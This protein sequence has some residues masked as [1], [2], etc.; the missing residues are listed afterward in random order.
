MVIDHTHLLHQDKHVYH[1]EENY[2]ISR[3]TTFWLW[4]LEQDFYYRNNDAPHQY[5]VLR[6][7]VARTEMHLRFNDLIADCE[8]E[9]SKTADLIISNARRKIR[10]CEA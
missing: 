9:E 1:F 10:C 3:M 2:D 5:F 7:E 6:D 8:V 4:L